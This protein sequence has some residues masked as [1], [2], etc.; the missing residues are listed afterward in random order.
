MMPARKKRPKMG[1][2]E[3]SV[4]RSP[5]HLQWIRGH[6]CVCAEKTYPKEMEGVLR[7]IRHKC[8]GRIQAM[9]VR[10]GTDGGTA[11]KP[12]DNW[13]IPGCESAHAEQH[14]IGE[15]SFEKRYGVKMKEIAEK[16][17][18]LSPHGRKWRLEHEQA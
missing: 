15:Q 14:Q 8:E 2:R 3:S 10:I 5:G 18:N 13:T 4:I 11:M 17:W 9:H 6:E 7:F 1:V 16:L 12:G